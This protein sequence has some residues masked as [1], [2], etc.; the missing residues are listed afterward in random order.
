MVLEFNEDLNN[1]VD[2]IE[3]K[4][5]FNKVKDIYNYDLSIDYYEFLKECNGFD[6]NGYTIY[7]TYNFIDYNE[8]YEPIFYK[9]NIIIGEY[10]I[11]FFIINL[12][13]NCCW[14]LD[15]PSGNKIQKFASLKEMIKYIINHSIK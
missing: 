3:I 10:D 14:E 9:E 13:D 15:K 1:K 2:E 7:G 6:F 12:R 8:A 5:L 4:A 11:G